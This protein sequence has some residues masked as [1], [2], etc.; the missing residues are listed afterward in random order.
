MPTFAGLY[1]YE[2]VLLVLGV[3]FFVMLLMAL[4]RNLAADKSYAGLIPFFVLSIAMMGYPSIT[5]I[6]YNN[7]MVQISTAAEQIDQHPND[8]QNKVLKEQ[9]QAQLSRWQR[10]ASNAQDL[11]TVAKARDVLDA[12]EAKNGK[13]AEAVPDQQAKDNELRQRVLTLTDQSEKNS[14]DAGLRNQLK[15]AVNELKASG[16]NDQLDGPVIKRAENFLE[17]FERNEQ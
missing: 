12:K 10:R 8:P 7:G 5:S 4:R 9:L 17:P 16:G 11:A 1:W 6:E 3:V 13:S 15:E 2:V 14:K